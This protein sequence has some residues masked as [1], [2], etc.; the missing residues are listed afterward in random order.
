MTLIRIHLFESKINEYYLSCMPSIQAVL[1]KSFLAEWPFYRFSIERLYERLAMQV[2]S[3][4]NVAVAD[5]LIEKRDRMQLFTDKGSL[6]W[7]EGMAGSF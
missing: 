2:P 6:A 4:I 5:K 3:E 7:S 1:D